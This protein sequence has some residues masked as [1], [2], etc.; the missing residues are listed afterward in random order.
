MRSSDNGQAI[1]GFIFDLGNVLV[2]LDASSIPRALV[3]WKEDSFIINEIKEIYDQWE[4]GK[5]NTEFFVQ[6]IQPLL[7]S[8]MGRMEFEKQWGEVLAGPM[9]G[10]E[11][12]LKRLRKKVRLALLSNVNPLHWK[13]VLK[14]YQNFL[15]YFEALFPS[16]QT[17]HLKPNS[18]S[19]LQIAQFFRLELNQ[20][21][22]VDDRLENVRAA[23]KMGILAHHFESLEL[24]EEWLKRN[25]LL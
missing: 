6:A 2:R 9:L 7:P 15:T 12:L 18:E 21:A 11:S 22:F 17:G 1:Q 25:N 13:I 8:P 5:I 10:M 4:S 14:D 23:Q 20:L 16:F 24:F 19:Y 3:L